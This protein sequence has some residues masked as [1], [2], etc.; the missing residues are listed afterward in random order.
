MG[1][2]ESVAGTLKRMQG[3]GPLHC[4]GA[5][6]TT[7]AHCCTAGRLVP[8]S[9]ATAPWR[10]RRAGL[11]CAST[12]AAARAR[13]G[14]IAP[15]APAPTARPELARGGSGRR[16]GAAR[17]PERRTLRGRATRRQRPPTGQLR[18]M[19]TRAQARMTKAQPRRRGRSGRA[20]AAT[21]RVASRVLV[22][23]MAHMCR[24]PPPPP[25]PPSMPMPPRLPQPL[26]PR[27]LQSHRQCP[28][29]PR[30]QSGTA[31]TRRSRKR[32]S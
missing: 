13:A 22:P 1:A 23:G 8:Q 17:R 30:A 21:V 25:P 6:L 15:P 10:A 24:P 12:R 11:A 32:R 27:H 20:L 29:A 31:R 28:Q 2:S 5:A 16:R 3:R 14:A 7:A 18:W 26:P 19:R 9:P 4:T